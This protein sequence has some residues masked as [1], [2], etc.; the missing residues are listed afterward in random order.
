MNANLTHGEQM[1][2]AKSFFSRFGRPIL[3]AVLV[4]ALAGAGYWGYKS[5]RTQ[6]NEKASTLFSQMTQQY[7]QKNAKSARANAEK[8]SK[9]YDGTTYAMLAELY[10]ARMDVDAGNT[11]QAAARLAKLK[12][13]DL[14]TGFDR[15]AALTLAR[16][17]LGQGKAADALKDL[18]SLN[19][20]EFAAE[21]E[22]LRG[23]AYLALK[24]P[25]D[26][27]KAY[28]AAL[29]KLDQNDPYRAIVQ[30]KLDDLGEAA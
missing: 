15:F 30:L 9:D 29:A 22:E 26:A 10:L 1:Q 16:I 6:Q 4:A 24:R 12:Q 13:A 14:P 11:A 23:D 27:R 8:L 7:E 19:P 3:A 5:Y 18:Q 20:G 25:A 21:Y 2:Q 17:H 28:Q